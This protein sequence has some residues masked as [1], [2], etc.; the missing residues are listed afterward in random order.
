VVY[1]LQLWVGQWRRVRPLWQLRP[2]FAEHQWSLCEVVIAHYQE[3]PEELAGTLRAALV[4][5]LL[6]FHLSFSLRFR[7]IKFFFPL[8]FTK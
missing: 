3:P 8:N 7:L 2:A 5:T 1:W 4:P 6:C